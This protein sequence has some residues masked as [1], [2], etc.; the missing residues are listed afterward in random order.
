MNEH[1]ENIDEYIENEIFNKKKGIKERLMILDDDDDDSSDEEENEQLETNN[2]TTE[3]QEI[4]LMID[5]DDSE[6]DEEEEETKSE[7]I[8][9]QGITGSNLESSCIVDDIKIES[10]N[11][12]D[13]AINKILT[14]DN[15]EQTEQKAEIEI[16]KTNAF[17]KH[18]APIKMESQEL[19]QSLT[20]DSQLTSKLM[21]DDDSEGEEDDS[22]IDEKPSQQLLLPSKPIKK[23]QQ[24][25][26]QQKE[27]PTRSTEGIIHIPEIQTSSI[28]EEIVT[29]RVKKL[30]EREKQSQLKLNQ[31]SKSQK[32]KL[33]PKLRQPKSY[34]SP[35]HTPHRKQSTMSAPMVTN[36]IETPR[37]SHSMRTPKS[38]S[39]PSRIRSEVENHLKR[40]V[41]PPGPAGEHYVQHLFSKHKSLTAK[42]VQAMS[43][44]I[45]ADHSIME[46][47][48]EI[49]LKTPSKINPI[50]TTPFLDMKKKLSELEMEKQIDERINLAML[51]DN[52]IYL[53]KKIPLIG[54]YVSK[55]EHM[56]HVFGD[57]RILLSDET[58][59]TVMA[60]VHHK[61]IEEYPDI[62]EAGTVIILE[63][64][65]VIQTSPGYYFLVLCH[66]NI[67]HVFAQDG[68]AILSVSETK[69][70]NP[71]DFNF[72]SEF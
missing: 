35:Q 5:E 15:R 34:K 28:E 65:S 47:A 63:S 71:R 8:Q 53:S 51:A 25:Q 49:L 42:Q 59:K 36:R 54:C 12:M 10:S 27:I 69:A 3:S 7:L 31:L 32:K 20:T 22:M 18:K 62:I 55:C 4:M 58:N 50:G 40:F 19:S 21:L 6:E 24:S 1:S 56:D 37:R 61:A 16:K 39:T 13:D 46:E 70:R 17:F 26:Q 72:I 48:K 30:I 41:V 11:T 45:M 38:P 29:E 2:K 68:E 9:S 60:S 43:Q 44:S 14:G 64:I 66:P 33:T 52:P 57:A 23:Q 67:L